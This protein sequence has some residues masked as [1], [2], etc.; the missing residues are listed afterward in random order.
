MVGSPQTA[1]GLTPGL[2]TRT[3]IPA[4]FLDYRLAP[5]A[6]VPGRVLARCG[7]D[8]SRGEHRDQGR[9]GPLLDRASLDR[10]SSFYI[11]G[12]DRRDRCSAR[13]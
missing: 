1:L 3:G 12:Q 11:A 5:G 4:I 2:V 7:R 13:R 10:M 6:P 8:A 9:C